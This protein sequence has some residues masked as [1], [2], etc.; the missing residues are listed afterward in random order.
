M[1][2]FTKKWKTKFWFRSRSRFLYWN[3]IF[4]KSELFEK[5]IGMFDF[6][7]L[8]VYIALKRYC[9]GWW[10]YSGYAL[11]Y[12]IFYAVLIWILEFQRLMQVH[13]YK[14]LQD[15]RKPFSSC[16]PNEEWP[17]IALSWY[18]ENEK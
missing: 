3:G 7:I 17:R 9:L 15:Y 13:R 12:A 6:V 1:L 10:N 8:D 11:R 5:N 18:N 4:Y 2:W 14:H 16:K